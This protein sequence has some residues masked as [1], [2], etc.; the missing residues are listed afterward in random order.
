[1]RNE[2]RAV[3]DRASERYDFAFDLPASPGTGNEHDRTFDE[4]A[5]P[6]SFLGRLAM[7][8]LE[9]LRKRRNRMAL[10]ELSDDQLKDIGVS[11]GEAYGGYSR[12]R[13][14]NVHGVERK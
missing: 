13:R 1:M 11:R 4:P 14:S 9:R 12:Y 5:L 10:L 7:L 6:R 8:T 3:F 2:N